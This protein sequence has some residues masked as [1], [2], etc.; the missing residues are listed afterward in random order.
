[1]AAEIFQLS[2][3]WGGQGSRVVSLDL[4]NGLKAAGNRLHPSLAVGFAV[5]DKGNANPAMFPL[6]AM[7]ELRRNLQD[8]VPAGR[9][10]WSPWGDVLYVPVP[11]PEIQ[12]LADEADRDDE[13]RVPLWLKF[14]VIIPLDDATKTSYPTAPT[15]IM[16]TAQPQ[17][18]L[19]PSGR[20]QTFLKAWGFPESRFVPLP[21][22]LP[23]AVLEMAP[24]AR[25]CWD[26]VVDALRKAIEDQRAGDWPRAGQELRRCADHLLYTWCAVWGGG[27]DAEDRVT[28]KVISFLDAAIPKCNP[29]TGRFPDRDESVELQRACARYG[30]L[31]S[32]HRA[33]QPMMHV[34]RKPVYT[35]EDVD[36]LLTSLTALARAFPAFWAE[37][38]SPPTFAEA[39]VEES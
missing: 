29:A 19:I 9:S 12:R 2:S 22:T 16:H 14:A 3:Q 39:A 38:P 25:S 28:A 36:Y 23:P 30:L 11:E 10:G 5:V 21:L 37:I 6:M 27:A 26:V 15:L 8:F 18:V 13:G 35:R 24:S 17:Q 31:R 33:S 20:W 1:M 32:L 7:V 34:G 4:E